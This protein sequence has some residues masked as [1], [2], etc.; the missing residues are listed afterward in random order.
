MID[1]G[2]HQGMPFFVMDLVEGADLEQLLAQGIDHRRLARLLE[3]AARTLHTCHEAGILHRDLKPA[4]IL[5]RREDDR[6]LLADF[7]LALD[8]SAEKLTKTGQMLGSPSFMAPDQTLECALVACLPPDDQIAIGIDIE[9]V[10][11]L[12]PDSG[13]CRGPS[14]DR[15]TAGGTHLR[16]LTPV[17]RIRFCRIPRVFAQRHSA[18]EGSGDA[19]GSAGRAQTPLLPPLLLTSSI[20]PIEIARSIALHMS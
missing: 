15:S 14:V 11:A 4:N 9:I 17:R 18:P 1:A 5:V 20:P 10:S 7:G 2:A 13:T 12:R 8:E 6:A 16:V 3:E 19:V